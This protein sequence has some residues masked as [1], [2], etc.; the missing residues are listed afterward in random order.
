MSIDSLIR[1]DHMV[2]DV[3]FGIADT[4]EENCKLAKY[5]DAFEELT[6]CIYIY[7]HSSTYSSRE[8]DRTTPRSKLLCRSYLYLIF[9][10]LVSLCGRVA[11][12]IPRCPPEAK[13]AGSSPAVIEL[14]FEK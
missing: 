3:E 11:K 4:G 5:G 13:T 1:N 12:W 2:R 10:G 6:S 9:V 7:R 14:L 8:I